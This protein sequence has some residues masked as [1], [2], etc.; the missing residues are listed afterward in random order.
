MFKY[1]GKIASRFGLD[2]T[3]SIQY[4]FN[5]QGFRGR[6]NFDTAPK[7]A[8]FGCSLVFGIGVQEHLTFPYLFEHAHNYGMAGNYDNHDVMLV[9][10]KF[11]RS[12]L[13][14][15]E[16][17]VV[18]VWHRRDTECLMDF[19]EKL[20]GYH[21]R[22]FFCGTPLTCLDCYP[23]PKNLD[24]DVSGTHPGPATHFFW[25]KLLRSFCR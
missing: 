12:D 25:Y 9:L 24:T 17:S 19:Q 23:A 7:Y 21:I 5:E 6:T 13:H 22:Q 15:A 14:S 4:E 8:F 11:L 10:E 1:R 18:V 3:G 20:R 16:T 2:Q